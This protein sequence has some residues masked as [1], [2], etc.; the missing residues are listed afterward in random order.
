ME[1]FR[2]IPTRIKQIK[3]M[4]INQFLANNLFLE[5]GVLERAVCDEP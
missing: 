4:F 5:Y 2:R 3:M 1:D